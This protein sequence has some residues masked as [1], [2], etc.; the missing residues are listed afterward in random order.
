MKRASAVAY[1]LI[2]PLFCLIVYSYGLSTWFQADDFAWLS[3]RRQIYTGHDLLRVLFEPM[4]QGTIRPWSERLFFLVFQSIFGLDV[5]PYRVW[6][7]LTQFANLALIASITWRITGSRA[8]GFWAPVL[9]TANSALNTAMAWCSAYNQILCGFFL[10]AAFRCLLA[11]IDTGKRRYPI[12]QWLFFL[13]GFGALEVNAVYPALAASYTLLCAR[14]HFRGTL[15]LFAPSILFVIVHNIAAPKMSIGTYGIH[16]DRFMFGT[17]WEYWKHALVPSQL[18]VVPWIP[19]W[20]ADIATPVSIT[21]FSVA[22]LGFSVCTIRRRNL[23]PLFFLSWFVLALLPVLPLRDHFSDYYLTLPTIG[24]AEL[25][26][27]ALVYAWQGTSLT[28]V[29]A[30][31]LAGAYFF[32]MLPVDRIAAHWYYDRGREIQRV[33]LG[34]ERAHELHPRQ[35]I[36]LSG[37]GDNVFWNAVA[38]NAF[39]IVGV[40]EVYLTPDSAKRIAPHPDLGAVSDYVLPASAALAALKNDQAVVYA[41]GGERLRNITSAYTQTAFSQLTPEE[42]KRINVG[43][44]LLA[45]TLGPEWYPIENGYRWMPK[46]AT[47]RIGGPASAAEK[48]YV[49]GFCPRMQFE[50]GPLQMVIAI[51]GRTLPAVSLDKGS[52]AFNL[53]FNPPAETVGRPVLNV[54]IE[55]G[56]TVSPGGESRQLGLAFGVFEIR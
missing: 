9:W 33:I 12:G 15:P 54:S 32:L 39:V 18:H 48:L 8:A 25:A 51:D 27:W 10:L 52:D 26:A 43:N 49:T 20:F 17:L 11:Y 19:G 34:V 22:L 6:V 5:V 47:L 1:W 28:S 42:P 14:K 30:V 37:I 23:L 40:P 55:V 31:A 24:L 50:K 56:R 2:P 4:A 41:A 36:I 7:Y 29:A 53:V 44:S 21:F 46:R 3:L 45:Y 35:A 16:I 13:L 38:H